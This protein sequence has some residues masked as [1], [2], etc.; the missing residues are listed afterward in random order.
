[1]G[2]IILPRVK[3]ALETRRKSAIDNLLNRE[4]AV[5]GLHLAVEALKKKYPHAD[6]RQVGPCHTFNCHGLTFG[7]R[8]TWIDNPSEILK[9]IKEDDYEVVQFRDI[10]VGD[11]AVYFV[12]GDVE[13][14]GIVVEITAAGPRILSKWGPC[15][16]VVH[17]VAE[18]EYEASNVV[19]Y[20]I[21]E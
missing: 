12:N 10:S 18:C 16:E 19:Y 11:I 15:Q 21:S 1:M 9:I 20:R 17:L 2:S 3:L 14:S 6:H 4:R 8:R 13:H 7:S 5:A